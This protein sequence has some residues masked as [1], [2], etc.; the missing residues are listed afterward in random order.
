M[1]Q[2]DLRVFR[3]MKAVFLDHILLSKSRLN[4]ETWPSVSALLFYQNLM[5]FLSIM[6]HLFMN[7]PEKCVLIL[8][9]VKRLVNYF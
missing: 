1:Y 6:W 7:G 3:Q 4:I 8:D 5:D 9:W 2:S